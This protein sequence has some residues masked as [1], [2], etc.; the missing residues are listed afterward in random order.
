M[1]V[2]THNNMYVYTCNTQ[3]K[4]YPLTASSRGVSTGTARTTPAAERGR[5]GPP[6]HIFFFKKGQ[7]QSQEVSA[8]IHLLDEKKN[9]YWMKKRKKEKVY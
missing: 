4:K 3:K 1:Y 5:G 8:L 2:Y 7:I 6:R 9:I